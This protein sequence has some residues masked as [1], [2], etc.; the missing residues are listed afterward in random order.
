MAENVAYAIGQYRSSLKGDEENPYF[1]ESSSE[2]S[3]GGLNWE[4][5]DLLT[6]SSIGNEEKEN[7][8]INNSFKDIVI[9]YGNN[10]DL[11]SSGGFV[12][13][14]TYFVRFKIK[15]S[16]AYDLTYDIKLEKIKSSITNNGNKYYI[17]NND[18]SYQFLKRITVEKGMSEAKNFVNN[19]VLYKDAPTEDGISIGV[20]DANV[21]I[22]IDNESDANVENYYSNIAVKTDNGYKII[23][24]NGVKLEEPVNKTIDETND[25]TVEQSWQTN[26]DD[27]ESSAYETVEILFTPIG[28]DSDTYNAITISLI[29][30]VIDYNTQYSENGS[31]FYGRKIGIYDD[32]VLGTVTNLLENNNYFPSKT[33]NKVGIWG[34][35][36]LPLMINGQEIRIGHNG[37][38]EVNIDGFTINSI[39]VVSEDLNRDRFLIDYQ[40]QI[41]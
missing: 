1:E 14:K 23:K 8:D 26:S 36:D 3:S 31:T 33:L 21:A 13:G 22:V 18:Q 4:I 2:P 37:F 7:L 11:N 29:K 32:I 10:G 19:I 25:I 38:Y 35:S 20:N 5:G 16:V 17:A 30:G 6:S 15:R 9:F 39:G 24:Q 40:Y 34:H 41:Q 12:A 27:D 28:S